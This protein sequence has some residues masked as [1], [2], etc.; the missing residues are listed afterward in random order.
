MSNSL[1]VAL[2]GFVAFIITLSAHEFAHALAGHFLGDETARRAGRLTLNPLA[3]I[4]P[5]GT[6]LIP[7]LGSLSGLPLIGWAKPVPY[8]PYNLKHGKWGAV[9]V[10]F[11]GPVTNVIVAALA[12]TM[13]LA[14]APSLSQDNLLVVLLADLV[15]VSLSLALFNLIPVP[16]LDGSRLLLSIFDAPRHRSLRLFVETRGP[17]ILILI[18]FADFFTDGRLLGP[19]FQGFFHT[20]FWLFGA[21]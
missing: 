6:V 10:A 12:M 7:I 14:L 19:I 20:F 15:M 21:T 11:A 3:H 2:L 1:I 8:N 5:I 17:L 13:Y 16:P 18:V 9:I 4:D